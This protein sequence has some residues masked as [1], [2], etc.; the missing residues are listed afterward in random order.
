[1]SVRPFDYSILRAWTQ[2]TMKW[3]V[4]NMRT[5]LMAAVSAKAIFYERFNPTLI[6]LQST[7]SIR[8][9]LYHVG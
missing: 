3:T 7:S 9:R 6:E 4:G 1:M 8:W 2:L 5:H